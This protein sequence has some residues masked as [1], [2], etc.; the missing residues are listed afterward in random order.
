M[1][2][3]VDAVIQA[4]ATPPSLKEMG[5]LMAKIKKKVEGRADLRFISVLLKECL[6]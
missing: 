3:I 4:E 6:S 2:A 1:R 5:S